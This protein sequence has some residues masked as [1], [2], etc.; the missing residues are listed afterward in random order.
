MEK[1]KR[2]KTVMVVDSHRLSRV[3]LARIL[4][5]ANLAV[6]VVDT[7]EQALIEAAASAP[8]AFII[9]VE[10]PDIGGLE[11]CARL[12]GDP[13]FRFTP[14]IM[15][16]ALDEGALLRRAFAAGCDDFLTKPLEPVVVAAR[17]T[18]QLQKYEIFQQLDRV[19]RNLARYISPRLRRLI[20]QSCEAGEPLPP[21]ERN[22]CILFSD[23]RGFTALSQT[24]PPPL[25]FSTISHQL[26][27]QVEVVYRHRGYIDK[28]G[29]DGIMAVFD[30]DTMAWDACS[31]AL[32]IMRLAETMP[33][34]NEPSMPVGIGIHIGPVVEGNIGSGEHMDYSV[35]GN[36]VNLAARLCGYAHS[37][38]IIVS[39]T[40]RAAVGDDADMRFVEPQQAHIRGLRTPIRLYRLAGPDELGQSAVAR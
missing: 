26:G 3:A 21:Q 1:T 4:E 16:T 5:S 22:V 35:I 24:I 15:M 28:F 20:E 23:I 13:R 33:F 9:D 37:R 14:I 25:L 7:A 36:T 18:G 34:N 38:D 10:M 17:V 40:V 12:R 29:G 27:A 39:E 32:E 19:R 31:C 2:Q 8:D 11:L 30:G 6:T